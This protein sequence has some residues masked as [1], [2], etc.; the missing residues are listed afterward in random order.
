MFHVPHFLAVHDVLDASNSKVSPC[1][2]IMKAKHADKVDV[3]PSVAR[4]IHLEAVP[5]GWGHFAKL[6]KRRCI[7][8]FFKV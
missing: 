6:S 2:L 3:E 8:T 1:W 7:W 4:L 5:W